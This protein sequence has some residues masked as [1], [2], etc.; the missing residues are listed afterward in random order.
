[1]NKLSLFSILL[2]LFGEALIALIFFY[3]IPEWALP[4]NLRV[5]DF[6]VVTA[7]FVIWMSNLCRPMVNLKDKSGKQ[8]AGLGVKWFAQGLYTLCALG[9]VVISLVTGWSG[10]LT[11]MVFKTY[12]LVQLG[13]F[14]LFLLGMM[15]AMASHRKAAEVYAQEK[16]V[17]SGKKAVRQYLADLS[18][19][20][21]D[22]PG[23]PD[24]IRRRISEL[25]SETR[26]IT[27]SESPEALRA[28]DKITGCCD[29]IEFALRDYGMNK[30]AVERDLDQLGREIARR[31]KAF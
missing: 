10:E 11:A 12:L 27:P 2:A 1:M 5:L 20:A 3:L 22:A 18:N 13:L 8:V 28:D 19:A 7:V 21:E 16:A 29:R 31:R 9:V 6:V 30:D 14:F 24:D 23:V 4:T 26:Y 25:A 15:G 17:K